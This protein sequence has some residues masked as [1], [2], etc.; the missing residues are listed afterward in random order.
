MAIGMATMV[1]RY[2]LMVSV[3]LLLTGCPH[4]TEVKAPVASHV[5]SSQQNR[6]VPV[7]TRVNVRGALNVSLHTG[8]ARPSVILRGDPRDL[9]YLT[10]TVVNGV[11]RVVL[12]EGY[13]QHGGIQ[14]EINT[15]YLNAFEYHGTGVVTGRSL[16]TSMLDLVID[17]PQKSSF[18]G[19]IGLRKL[20]AMGGGYTEVSGINSPYLTLSISGKSMVRLSGRM[21]LSTI[22]IQKEGRLSLYWVK[23]RDLLIRARGKSFIQLAGVADKLNVELWDNARFNGRYLRAERAFVKTHGKSVAEISAVK[24]QHTLASDASDIHFYNI[25]TMK[26]DFMAYDGAV[27]DMRDLGLPF[28]QEYNQYNK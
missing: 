4:S 1:L 13:P 27:L 2:L 11:L 21:N 16:R 5:A 12:G 3:V 18:Q 14:V 26:A 24:R 22:D 17:N 8:V 6:P 19:Q 7:F 28:I 25:P 10:T 9:A 20:V 23:S 15:R